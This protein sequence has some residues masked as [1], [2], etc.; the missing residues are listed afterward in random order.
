MKSSSADAMT[1]H[2]DSNMLAVSCGDRVLR[3]VD[4][5]TRRIVRELDC[6]ARI[7]DVVR[8]PPSLPQR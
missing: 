3:I 7:R 6:R 1:L 2:A 8:P 5:E 4:L